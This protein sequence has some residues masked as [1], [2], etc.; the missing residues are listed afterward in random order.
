M[1]LHRLHVLGRVILASVVALTIIGAS[2]L[3]S[4]PAVNPANL[5]RQLN[6]YGRQIEIHAHN[7]HWALVG[8]ENR[9]KTILYSRKQLER[10]RQLGS[11]PQREYWLRE[12][13]LAVEEAAANRKLAAEEGR[14]KRELEEAYYKLWESAPPDFWESIPVSPPQIP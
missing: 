5:S 4:A 8:A 1:W 14:K 12:L 11:P 10:V 9:R 13:N 7:E 3:L 6:E 2:Y